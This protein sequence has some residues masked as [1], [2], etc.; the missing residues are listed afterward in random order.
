MRNIPTQPDLDLNISSPTEQAVIKG[1]GS[2]N[3][4][5][6]H[7]ASLVAAPNARPTLSVGT[8]IEEQGRVICSDSCGVKKTN[9]VPKHRLKM[10]RKQIERL[11][12]FVLRVE[13]RE[14]VC[15]LFLTPENHL[16]REIVEVS[17]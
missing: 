3:D 15:H 1:Q 12:G 5:H 6:S 17:S 13:L 10:K 2:D 14:I 8:T 11:G 9:W 7:D 16:V 4:L